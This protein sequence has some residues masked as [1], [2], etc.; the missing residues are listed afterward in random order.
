M[1]RKDPLQRLRSRD[2]VRLMQETE[3]FEQSLVK[4]IIIL[5]S[6]SFYLVGTQRYTMFA[7]VT[8]IRTADSR[9]GCPISR[10]GCGTCEGALILIL[11]LKQHLL[12]LLII[13]FVLYYR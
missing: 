6:R 10:S 5:L 8:H 7:F 4:V 13:L 12:Q 9:M 1:K 3:N 2:S 11:V